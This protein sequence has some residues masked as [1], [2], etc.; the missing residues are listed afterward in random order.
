MSD[1]YHSA[2]LISGATDLGPL[3]GYERHDLVRSKGSGLVFMRRIPTPQELSDHYDHYS[4][5]GVVSP[6]TY[7]RY[8]EL[9]KKWEP[10]RQTNKILDV[11]CGDGNFLEVAKEMGWDV[12]GSEFTEDASRRAREKGVTMFV[13]KLDAAAIDT[14]DF[15]IITSF[16]VMEHINNPVEQATHIFNLL[17]K[18]GLFYFTTP[19]FNALERYY[20]KVDYPVINYPE[21]LIYWTPKTIHLLL[22]GVG[23]RKRKIET[24]G[25]N[26]SSF[27]SRRG[28]GQQKRGG[29]RQADA[30]LR[31]TIE[32]NAVLRLAKSVINWVLNL[33]GLGNSLKGHF[34]KPM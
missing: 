13:G 30:E 6:I 29:I 32:S 31:E 3:K 21:H 11:G 2:C 8:R 27:K 17:R 20:L 10:F 14:K 25:I 7:S 1:H 5:G 22:K 4:R 19:N 34:I 24:T 16:E 33:T 18:G 15:D 26:I 23:F 12:Y 9:L 28:K